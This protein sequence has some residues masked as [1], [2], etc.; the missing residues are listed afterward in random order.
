MLRE[1]SAIF[2]AGYTILLVVLVMKVHDGTNAF[3]DYAHTLRSP[4]LI[5]VNIVALLF[6]LLHSVTWF[7]ATPTA[8][9]PRHGEGR[10]SSLLLIGV[11]YV[12]ML[13]LTAIV[14]VIV[15]V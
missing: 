3:R 9:P 10:A 12:V 14:L 7:Q 5:A 6:A 13:G 2:L 8:L 4:A 15:L 1:L 11:N